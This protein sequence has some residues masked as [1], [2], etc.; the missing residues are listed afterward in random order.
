MKTKNLIL[1]SCLFLASCISQDGDLDEYG[2]TFSIANNT[3]QT[4]ENA[5]ITIGGMKDG[6]FIGTESYKLPILKI[7]GYYDWNTYGDN[8]EEIAI[9]QNRWNPN[10]DLI[11]AIP[12]EKVYFKLKLAEGSET[13]L[14][15]VNF[16]NGTLTTLVSRAIPKGYSFYNDDGDLSIAIWEEGIISR[17]Y[18][19]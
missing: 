2:I 8:R 14:R 10:L 13:L 19:N 16:E 18:E 1:I 3:N 9:G 17:L 6:E 5:S 4:Y 7:I 15:N 12:S 11:R